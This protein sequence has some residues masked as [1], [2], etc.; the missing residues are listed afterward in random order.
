[1]AT[2]DPHS[3]LPQ[4]KPRTLTLLII[5]L[6]LIGLMVGG[7][8]HIINNRVGVGANGAYRQRCPF[9]GDGLYCHRY[10]L[11]ETH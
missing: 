6:M 4:L 9:W 3:L 8:H 11:Y 10:G 7:I 1:M 5:G 2:P